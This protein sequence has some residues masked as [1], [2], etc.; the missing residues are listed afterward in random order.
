MDNS[1]KFFPATIIR[2]FFFNNLRLL[3]KKNDFYSKF[4][5]NSNQHLILSI[6]V[7]YILTV[8]ILIISYA[9]AS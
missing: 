6:D 3:S 1:V 7:I 4:V 8:F 2:D 9:I 5:K